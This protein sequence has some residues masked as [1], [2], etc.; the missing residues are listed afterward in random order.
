[1]RY[2][3]LSDIHA[4]RAALDA[5]L[6]DAGGTYDQILNLGDVVGY[7]PD[8]DYAAEFSREHC[9]YTVRGNH[10]K[11]AAGL[12]DL[13]W[14]NPVARLS[15][16]WTGMALSQTNAEWVA[17]LPAGPLE[18][19]GF[20]LVHGSPGDE[21]EYILGPAEARD[22][23]DEALGGLSFFGH[24]HVQGGFEVHRSGIRVI[25]PGPVLVDENSSWLV[26]PGSVGQPRDGDPRAA[27]AIYDSSERTVSYRRTL[28][29]VADTH[30][31]ILEAGLPEVLGLRLFRGA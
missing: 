28:Y 29:D 8:P 23:A 17:A 26:N 27:W 1:V 11:A 31:R 6:A 24:T 25:G 13:E 14:F 5:V 16:N 20:S 3:I 30:K 4:N 18:V 15:A 12:I 19:D 9:V 21:D 22:A 7:G 10:D 2:L